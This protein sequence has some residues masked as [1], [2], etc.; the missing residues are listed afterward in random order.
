MGF[1][2]QGRKTT[3]QIHRD[4]QTLVLKDVNTG[5]RRIKTLT[6]VVELLRQAFHES[7]NEMVCMSIE[8]GCRS[9]Y[10]GSVRLKGCQKFPQ[11]QATAELAQSSRRQGAQNCV[12]TRADGSS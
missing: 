5:T 10:D 2:H 12:T 1:Q 6:L 11:L 9:H 7:S 4:R 3:S 8:V